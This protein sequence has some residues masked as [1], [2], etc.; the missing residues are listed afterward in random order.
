MD[1]EMLVRSYQKSAV[2]FICQWAFF[3]LR[4]LCERDK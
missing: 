4:M 2:A 3:E 1:N